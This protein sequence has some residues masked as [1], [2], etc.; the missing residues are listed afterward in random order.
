MSETTPAASA[1]I[2]LV[3]DEAPILR[4]FRW[5]LED[6][7]YRV[8]TAQNGA[9]ALAA[10]EREV[11]DVCFLDVGIGEESG[12]DLLPRLKR[13]APWM[14]VV[15]ATANS[16]VDTAVD[17]MRAGASDYLVKPFTPDQLRLAANGRSMRGAW[18]RASTRWK[19]SASRTRRPTSRRRRRR[20]AQS[21]DDRAPRR[22]HR[23]H[24]C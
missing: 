20:M 11:F 23:R 6:D 18:K 21:L 24:R 4:T 9:Q 19:A 7:G 5:C 17:A 1:R 10:L 2:L 8:T 16:S 3:D 12:L 14:R 13:A 15:M 22:R